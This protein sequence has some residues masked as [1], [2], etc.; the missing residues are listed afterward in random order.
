M[1]L[2]SILLYAVAAVLCLYLGYSFV[3]A[4]PEGAHSAPSFSVHQGESVQAVARALQRGG[5]IR[6]ARFFISLTR[7]SGTARSIKAGEYEFRGGMKTTDMVRAF[8]RG[9][10]VM[11]RFTVPEGLHIRQV[12]ELLQSEGI[13]PSDEFIE[14]CSSRRLLEKW[15]IPFSSAEGFLFPDTYVVAKGLDASRIAE[16]MIRRFF[17]V[18]AEVPFKGENP[19]ALRRVVIVASLVEKEAKLD[20]E[21]A[22]ISAVFYNRL[23]LGKRLESCATVQYVL[24]KPKERLLF[25]DLKVNSPYN[26][27][28]HAGLPPGPIANPGKKSLDAAVHP[29]AVGYLFFV[30]KANG[31][32]QFSSTYE[33]HLKAIRRYGSAVKVGHQLS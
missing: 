6:S 16:V 25:S 12:A 2:L 9:A 5:Y 14:A 8:A 1:K 3:N 19:D 7:L 13:V 33:E 31:S 27:Y 20:E 11:E 15:G 32:H 28:L 21:R 24:Q 22:L 26:T 10:I 4:P 18:L 23:K 29:A 30:V 17:E